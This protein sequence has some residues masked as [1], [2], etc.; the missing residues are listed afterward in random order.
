M[1]RLLDE[2]TALEPLGRGRYR[3][4][5]DEGPF[6]GMAT[7]HGGY[8]MALVLRAMQLELDESLPAPTSQSTRRPRVLSQQ[9]LGRVPVGDV[10]IEVQ[11]ERTGR[12]VSSLTARLRTA[13]ETRAFASG[14][15]TRD[16]EGPGFLDDPA[17]AVAPPGEPDV[18]LFG[19]GAP[20]HAGFEFHR[21][22]GSDGAVVPVEDGGWIVPR[23]PGPWDH[24]LALVA[25]DLWVPAIIRHPERVCATP[26]LHHVVHFGP[27]VG[28]ADT[29]PLLVRHRLSSGGSGLTDED[30][31]LWAEDGRLL[32]RARQLRTVIDAQVLLAAS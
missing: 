11:V 6:W 24:R 7:P 29:T 25:S 9:F 21:R 10:D 8:L 16:S 15:F 32:L 26:S 12:N 5:L 13:G 4:K 1:S 28:G 19:F 22:F 18:E 14:L 2:Q 30:I 17:P 31:A 3:R 20:V 23:E 27:Q